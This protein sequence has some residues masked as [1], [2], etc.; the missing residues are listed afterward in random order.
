M[1]LPPGGQRNRRLTLVCWLGHEGFGS[2]P[3]LE[4][5]RKLGKTWNFV[6]RFCL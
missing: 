6:Q 5:E 4:I 3:A 1:S 2:V